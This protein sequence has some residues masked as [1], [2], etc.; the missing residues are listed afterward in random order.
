VL[1][2]VYGGGGNSGAPLR[3]DFIELFN[4]GSSAVNLSGWSVQYSGATA[5]TWNVTLLPTVLLAP[6][7]YF[8]I[9]EASG[10]T[11]GS[12][13]PAPDVIG[14][15]NLAATAGKVALV[16]A[17]SALTGSCPSDPNIADLVGYGNTASCFEGMAPAIAPSNTTAIVRG[18]GGCSDT[19]NNAADFS[20][21]AANPRNTASA[22]HSCS[23]Q[24]GW[25][26]FQTELD[27]LLSVCLKSE[28]NF[29]SASPPAKRMW[30]CPSVTVTPLSSG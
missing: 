7:Q 28:L 4:A 17:T 9:Q 21:A 26:Q 13:L 10:G 6:G 15:I 14:T 3:N 1:S 22:M 25:L 12:S 23:A 20:L 29:G 18:S 5:A 24:V 11:N 30:L 2:Q 8:L 16:H 19:H 27:L